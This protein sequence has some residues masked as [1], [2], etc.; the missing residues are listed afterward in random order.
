MSDR[1]TSDLARAIRAHW[2]TIMMVIVG[3]LGAGVLAALIVTVGRANSERDRA[4]TLQSHSFDVMLRARV[5]AETMARAEATLGRYVIS[6]EKRIGQQY[7][8]EWL[9]A[10]QQIDR[11]DS[12]VRDNPEQ[13]RQVDALRA[14]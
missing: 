11:L 4:L 12:V 1:G 7:S 5:L 2:R 14:A 3:A 10:G 8:D 9:R 13:A 6:G